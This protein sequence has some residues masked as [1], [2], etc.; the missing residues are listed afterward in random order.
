MISE[1]KI[2][3]FAVIKELE[4]ELRPG[5][6]IITGE[7]GAGKSV[8]I[9]AVSMA[10]G[11]RADTDYIRYG[12]QKAS[13]SMLA[14]WDEQGD[15][16]LAALLENEGIPAESPLIIKREISSQSRSVCRVNGEIVPL[17]VLSSICKHIADI[18]GQYDHQSLLDPE[19]HTGVLDMYGGKDVKSVLE[20]TGGACRDYF[21]ASSELMKLRKTL[22]D[23]KRE[24]EL[25]EHELGEIEA[26]GVR[27]GEAEALEDEIRMMRHSEQ[28]H[29]A[30]ENSYEELYGGDYSADSALS[31]AMSQLGG[32]RDLSPELR[33]IAES[34][35]SAFYQVDELSSQLRRLRDSFS[36]SESELDE[37]TERLELI[38]SLERKFGGSEESILKY[39]ED[40][41]EKLSFI[42]NSD[43]RVA[44]LE[45]SIKLAREKYD[46]CAA[47]LG[48]LRRETAE[49]VEKAVNK[50]L[51][52]LNFSGARFGVQFTDCGVSEQGSEK[53]QFM[54]AAN[55]GEPLKPLS[56]V[57]SGGELSRIMLALKCILG[58]ADSIPTMIFDEIDTGISGATAGIVG[59]KLRSISKDHQ[60]ICI[61]HL[62]QIACLGDQ[63]Y[64]IVKNT[65]ENSTET[66][67]TPLSREERI[68]EIARLL[69]G[70]NVSDSARQRAA[71]L[72]KEAG[73]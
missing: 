42:E 17:S 34:V 27:A 51:A 49:T 60:V 45:A 41:R 30:L 56:K 48:K 65:Y 37:K 14:E 6:N 26:A 43:A 21:S 12:A 70:T 57:A 7:T 66:T 20:M 11:S 35:E 13:I 44:E 36:F 39:A 24:R 52:E 71:E 25:L 33:D 2:R 19:R 22:S 40:A 73:N 54:I 50:E 32:V 67:V 29:S 63:H 68:D 64:R 28:I 53:A 9:E 72:L 3:D 1:L 23:S 55:P 18:H 5:L 46:V 8:I 58:D 47:R 10:L 62:P 38:H 69:S 16:D 15:K 31:R 59:E 4:L 61:T